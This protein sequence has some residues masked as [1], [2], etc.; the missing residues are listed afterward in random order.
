MGARSGS[1]AAPPSL[2]VREASNR[3]ARGGSLASCRSVHSARDLQLIGQPAAAGEGGTHGAPPHTTPASRRQAAREKL[4][5]SMR[6]TGTWAARQRGA[7]DHSA[8][9]LP[10]PPAACTSA[11]DS[12][13]PWPSR[14]PHAAA[15][16]AHE[17]AA[18][19]AARQLRAGGEGGGTTHRSH[20]AGA[21]HR[22]GPSL[23]RRKGSNTPCHLFAARAAR[24]A[25]HGCSSVAVRAPAGTP[26]ARRQLSSPGVR[27]GQQA[28]GARP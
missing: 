1:L 19:L 25:T 26:A 14:P 12:C 23:V 9:C 11:R 10:C 13:S 20:A 3:N 27:H 17:P 28:R 6:T 16:L 15:L 8:P 22:A 18:P 21:A 24:P 2:P 4:Q 5:R 7:G